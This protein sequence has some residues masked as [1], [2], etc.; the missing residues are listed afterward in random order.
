MT[1]VWDRSQHKGTALLL[2]LAISDNANE[3]CEAWPSV[4]TLARKVRMTERAVQNLIGQLVRSGELEVEQG[5]GKHHTNRYRICLKGESGNT[6]NFSPFGRN[7]EVS[8]PKGEIQRAQRVKNSARNGEVAASPEPGRTVKPEPSLPENREAGPAAA[9]DAIDETFIQALIQ[10][11]P[12][13]G[14]ARVRRGV[15]KATNNRNFLKARDPR[16]YVETWLAEDAEKFAAAAEP[17]KNGRGADR[18]LMESKFGYLGQPQNSRYRG[19]AE[20]RAELN[21]GT[22]LGLEESA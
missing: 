11:F 3:Q 10:Q 17:H 12:Q 9:R 2:L 4:A 18:E 22:V 19:D 6:E 21:G 15:S 7:G 14:D 16:L 1:Q 5:G 8:R 13:L 20:E